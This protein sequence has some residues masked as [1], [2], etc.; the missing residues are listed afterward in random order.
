MSDM[1]YIPNQSEKKVQQKVTD[2]MSGF[3]TVS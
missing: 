3:N 1:D 2:K